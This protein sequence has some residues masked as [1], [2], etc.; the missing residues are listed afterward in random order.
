MSPIATIAKSARTLGVFV[1][2]SSAALSAAAFQPV[3][4][5]D[6]PA[7]VLETAQKTAPG[8]TFDK[9]S[10]E[11]E[12]GVTVYEFEATDYRGRHIEVDVRADGSLEEIEMEIDESEVPDTVLAALNADQKDFTVRYIE[13]S[14]RANG[15]HVYEFEGITAAG[16]RLDIEIAEDGRILSR[17]GALS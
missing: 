2:V 9:V 12:A 15:F 14:V 7:H 6:V 3:S 17:E 13:V 5:E 1:S 4:F 8:V 16:G 10:T 11:N